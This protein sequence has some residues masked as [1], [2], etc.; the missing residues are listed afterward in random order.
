MSLMA[1]L[2]VEGAPP[3][4]T[5]KKETSEASSSKSSSAPSQLPPP[6]TGTMSTNS[7]RM[8]APRHGGPMNGSR[9]GLLV[10]DLFDVVVWKYL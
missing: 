10:R 9:P 4:P 3:P 5:S 6:P 2:G 8:N 7:N 1:E